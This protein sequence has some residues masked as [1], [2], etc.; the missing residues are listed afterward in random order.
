MTAATASRGA[1][2]AVNLGPGGGIEERLEPGNH[3]RDNPGDTCPCD[4]PRGGRGHLR[5]PSPRVEGIE[6]EP[7]GSS[8]KVV[9]GRLQHL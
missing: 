9:G 2:G 7:G 6:D 5:R 8:E 4:T 1:G 3:A